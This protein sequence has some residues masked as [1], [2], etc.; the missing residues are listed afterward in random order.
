[1]IRTATVIV[2]ALLLAGAPRHTLTAQRLFGSVVLADDKTPAR[3]ALIVAVDSAGIAQGREL[4]NARGEFVI[5]VSHPGRYTV[6]ARRV[7]SL[8][9]TVPNVVVRSSTCS[10]RNSSRSTP[11][12]RFV[13]VLRLKPAAI[14]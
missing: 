6:S 11:P 2:S 7:G 9:Q 5:P 14:F 1:M 4:A 13:K 8:E 12:S 3:G 10:V